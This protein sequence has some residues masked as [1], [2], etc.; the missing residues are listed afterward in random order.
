MSLNVIDINLLD[1]VYIYKTRRQEDTFIYSLLVGIDT[2]S[3]VTEEH[4]N[5]AKSYFVF[6]GHYKYNT[7]SDGLRSTFK[8][9]IKPRYGKDAK[10][11]FENLKKIAYCDLELLMNSR[12]NDWVLRDWSRM[13]IQLFKT[14]E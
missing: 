1:I 10:K 7:I 5:A 9:C 11:D 6:S 12:S 3:I 4:L 8:F 13:F 14:Q 2:D